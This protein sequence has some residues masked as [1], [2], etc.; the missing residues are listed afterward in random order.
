MD[1]LPPA[2]LKGVAEVLEM[3]AQKYGDYN[4]YNG[5]VFSRLYAAT[6]RHLVA[7]W[8]GE[9][10][11]PESGIDHVHHAMCNL[12][13]LAQFIHE[14]RDELDDRKFGVIEFGGD[15]DKQD[16]S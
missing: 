7:W 16:L 5:I 6:L 3:G 10:T 14:E 1:L 4:W 2:M 13:F 12:A 11:D 9:E 15:D 8:E